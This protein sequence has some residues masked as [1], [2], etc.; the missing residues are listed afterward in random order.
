MWGGGRELERQVNRA[1][2]RIGKGAAALSEAGTAVYSMS[3]A[4]QKQGLSG[5]LQPEASSDGTPAARAPREAAKPH[6]P[7][8]GP[9]DVGEKR[10]ILRLQLDGAMRENDSHRAQQLSRELDE[11]EGLSHAPGGL[12]RVPPPS[13]HTTPRTAA[14][15]GRPRGANTPPPA[16]AEDRAPLPSTGTGSAPPPPMDAAPTPRGGGCPGLPVDP[17]GRGWMPCLPPHHVHACCLHT[18]CP[19]THHGY[20]SGFGFARGFGDNE[21]AGAFMDGRAAFVSMEVPSSQMGRSAELP[22]FNGAAGAASP[23]RVEEVSD[24]TEMR[25]QTQAIVFHGADDSHPPPVGLP[26]RGETSTLGPPEP[27]PPAPSGLPPGMLLLQMR[28]TPQEAAAIP[29]AAH[30]TTQAAL[31]PQDGRVPVQ[32]EEEIPEPAG[33]PLQDIYE[34]DALLDM[35]MTAA[36]KREFLIKW[37]GWGPKWNNWEPEEH[38]LDKG[39]LRKFNKRTAEAA[40][41]FSDD[42]DN[43][44]MQSKRR[45]AK[46]AAVRARMAAREEDEGQ[47][48]ME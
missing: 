14:P 5:L 8:L 33:S 24:P 9:Q 39:M 45:C 3:H 21:A 32:E 44:T 30:P 34:V 22:H 37:K 46:P 17:H 43:I 15:E 16:R 12:R 10:A 1:L 29:D 18:C 23:P 28:G 26:D 41:P 36:G 11:L 13:M 19:H 20:C 31:T 35:R 7:R 40:Q 42:V 4:M 2:D 38:I 6:Q 47:C 27:T 48:K 25:E